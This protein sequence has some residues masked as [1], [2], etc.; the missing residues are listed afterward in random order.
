MLISDVEAITGLSRKSIRLYEA[1]GLLSAKRAENSYRY[2]D[3]Q[4]VEKLKCIA[5]LRRV[6]IPIAD[7]QLWQSGVISAEEMFSKRIH[8]L[9]SESYARADQISLCYRL[10]ENSDTGLWWELAGLGKKSRDALFDAASL[11]FY[12]LCSNRFDAD[13]LERCGA[14]AGILPAVT[15][16]CEVIGSYRGIPVA[17]AIGDNQASFLGA[18]KDQE[19]SALANF[20]T[21]SQISL[22]TSEIG[23]RPIFGGEIEVRPYV[24]CEFLL[25]GSGLCGG[26]AYAIIE[27][28]FRA[29]AVACG[30]PDTEQYEVLNRLAEKG[31]ESKNVLRVRTTFSGTRSDPD[32]RG[33]ISGISEDNFTPEA[34]AAGCLYGMAGELHE[35]YGK[36]GGTRQIDR[37]VAS[38]NA[39][40]KNR[41]LKKAPARGFIRAR[42]TRFITRSARWT[43]R[44][45]R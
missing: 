18:V 16:G 12:D 27:R 34:L 7:I 15:A 31:V 20:G 28:F 6:G 35:I 42:S 1:K 14:F 39:I 19:R 11:G 30:L 25:C 40:R 23:D 21:G 36:I 29:Y 41:I 44:P 4:T 22:V 5:V 9:K 2:F 17:V 13:A 33:E 10:M 3:E 37:L 43:A 38:G 24:D 45:R 32:M 8:Q 26:R